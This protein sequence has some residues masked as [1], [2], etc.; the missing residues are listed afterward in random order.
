MISQGYTH[1]LAGGGVRNAL[2]A[3]GIPGF[4]SKL[5]ESHSPLLTQRKIILF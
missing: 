1:L 2:C 5:L 3:A 4:M